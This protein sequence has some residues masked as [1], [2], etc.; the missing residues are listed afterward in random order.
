M[1]VNENLPLTD[2]FNLSSSRVDESY[3]TDFSSEF[4][5]KKIETKIIFDE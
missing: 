2:P 4:E 1:N 3:V 5:E